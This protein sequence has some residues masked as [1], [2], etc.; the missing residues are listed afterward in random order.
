MSKDVFREIY[1]FLG[2]V[3]PEPRSPQQSQ[4]GSE[5]LRQL[6]FSVGLAPPPAIDQASLDQ[7]RQIE[8]L[9]KE[10]YTSEN[11]DR[12]TAAEE[13]LTKNVMAT[14]PLI[15][16]QIFLKISQSHY[17]LVTN[18]IHFLLI[19]INLYKYYY[20]YSSLHYQR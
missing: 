14:D 12:R 15:R 19:S 4:D 5:V 17:L 16:C 2:S 13:T 8:A 1:D 7:L 6:D 10:V 11:N 18:N 9:S 20:F 3:S